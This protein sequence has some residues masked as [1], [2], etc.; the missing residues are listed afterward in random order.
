MVG[1]FSV[2]SFSLLLSLSPPLLSL[3][4]PLLLGLLPSSL[5]LLGFMLAFFAGFSLRVARVRT[6]ILRAAAAAV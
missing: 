5:F 4:L 3:S 6:L 2:L 1:A